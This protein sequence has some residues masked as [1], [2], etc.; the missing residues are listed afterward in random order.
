MPVTFKNRI[1][2]YL[3]TKL[4]G[5]R[6]IDLSELFP[7]SPV[8]APSPNPVQTVGGGGGVRAREAGTGLK[9]PAPHS[10]LFKERNVL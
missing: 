4:R 6:E 9:M 1:R 10:N 2:T 5:R 3:T 7:L 8:A